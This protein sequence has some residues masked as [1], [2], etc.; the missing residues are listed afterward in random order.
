[1]KKDVKHPF[2]IP[3]I[4]HITNF[5]FYFDFHEPGDN[6]TGFSYREK[7]TDYDLFRIVVITSKPF[8]ILKEMK[9]SELITLDG[10]E[11]FSFDNCTKNESFYFRP[12]IDDSQKKF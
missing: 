5:E 11:Y 6:T 7:Y 12:L 1:M 9:I 2:D 8:T 4:E 3:G 10:I